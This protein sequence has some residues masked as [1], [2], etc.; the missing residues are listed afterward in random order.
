MNFEFKIRQK[1]IESLSILLERHEQ[2]PISSH[3][4]PIVL[5]NFRDISNIILYINLKHTAHTNSLRFGCEIKREFDM[6]T[7]SIP[8][9]ISLNCIGVQEFVDEV[10]SRSSYHLDKDIRDLMNGFS[11]LGIGAHELHQHM[12]ELIAADIMES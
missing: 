10:V 2:N 1:V 9:P 7:M 6:V 4:A 5:F 11:G 8:K 12:L 3:I